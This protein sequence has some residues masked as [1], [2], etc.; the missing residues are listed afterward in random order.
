MNDIDARQA[1]IQA[2][3]AKAERTTN[4]HERAAFSE[5]AEEL[6]ARWGIDRAMLQAEE[7]RSEEIVTQFMT[8]P[9]SVGDTQKSFIQFCYVSLAGL[10]TVQFYISSDIEGTPREKQIKGQWSKKLAVV[11]YKSDVEDAIWLGQSLLLQAQMATTEWWKI[12]LRE[13]YGSAPP[14]PVR[15]KAKRSFL[16][17]YSYT[18]KGRLHAV[19]TRAKEESGTGT[20]LVL[21]DRKGNVDKYMAGLSLRSSRGG[22]KSADWSARAAG[23]VAGHGADLGQTKVTKGGRSQIGR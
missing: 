19:A 4:E 5:K 11:G 8:F 22:R 14:A 23:G 10:G 16:E 1:K 13:T 17:G 21:F 6:L 20:D 2:L 9:G 18:V 15:A 7:G 12:E 3:L